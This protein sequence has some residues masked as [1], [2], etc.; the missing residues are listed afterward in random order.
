MT[1]NRPSRHDGHVR[2]L[3]GSARSTTLNTLAKKKE[4]TFGGDEAAIKTMLQTVQG[5]IYTRG[6]LLII[7]LDY[8]LSLITDIKIKRDRNLENCENIN[9]ETKRK[10]L[11]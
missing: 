8:Q 11:V 10:R 9:S 2:Q 6:P 5:C 3:K 1:R 4:V 7:F